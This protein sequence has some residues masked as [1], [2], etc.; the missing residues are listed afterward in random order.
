MRLARR[1]DALRHIE[2]PLVAQDADDFGGE[3]TVQHVDG[4][5][6][7][8]LVSGGDG[9]LGHVFARS[10]AQLFDVLKEGALLVHHV[11]PF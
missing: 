6:K 9:S 3:H 10:P 5:P 11:P 1:V 4:L 8:E 7:V 2:M